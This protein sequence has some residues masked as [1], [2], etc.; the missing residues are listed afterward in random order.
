MRQIFSGILGILTV[1]LGIWLCYQMIWSW[2][3]LGAMG[4]S[5]APLVVGLLAGF[6]MRYSCA[7]GSFGLASWALALIF[8]YG[9]ACS[10]M[11]HKVLFDSR[12]KQEAN[13]AY[14]QTL[15]YAKHMVPVGDDDEALRRLM[16][17]T[18]VSVIGRITPIPGRHNHFD[19][20]E[21]RNFIH[22][23]WVATSRVIAYGETGV[24]KTIAE[25]SSILGDDIFLDKIIS[26]ISKNEP[27]SE[28]DLKRFRQYELPY[29]KRLADGEITATA[30]EQPLVDEVS[31]RVGWKT[32]ATNGFEPFLGMAMLFGGIVAYKLVRQPSDTE[33]V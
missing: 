2:G 3:L 18:E 31:S 30:F 13:A 17:N 10:A 28:D 24:D 16:N 6:A 26:S 7:E 14:E 23:H 20:W 32:F 1:T 19:Y 25:A 33:I 29:L 4:V 15:S 22:L 8:S 9:L 27:A 12:L 21:T 5:M 11:R